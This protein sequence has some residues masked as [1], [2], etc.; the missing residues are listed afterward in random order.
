MVI[1]SPAGEYLVAVFQLF[2][3]LYQRFL[4]ESKVGAHHWQHLQ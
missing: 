3:P 2:Q 4:N 1:G